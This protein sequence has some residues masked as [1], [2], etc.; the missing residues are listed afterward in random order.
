MCS[1][2]FVKKFRVFTVFF[3][4]IVFM[5]PGWQAV[6]AEDEEEAALDELHRDL[7][8][9]ESELSAEKASPAAEPEEEN[10]AKEVQEP[11]AESEKA[12][13]VAEKSE[14][15]KE[16]AEEWYD[17]EKPTGDACL[18]RCNRACTCRWEL[19]GGGPVIMALHHF[20]Y[21]SGYGNLD[22]FGV[23]AG[24]RGYGY[25]LDD[26]LR[27]GGMG[28]G[29]GLGSNVSQT[30]VAGKNIL[31]D[32]EYRTSSERSI[33]GGY[34]GMTLEYVFRMMDGAF[35]IPL[36]ALVGFG[37]AG[38]TSRVGKVESIGGEVVVREDGM[39]FALQPMA[40]V[41]I[42]AARWLRIGVAATALY[43]PVVQGDL[44]DLS[45]AGVMVNVMFG[46]FTHEALLWE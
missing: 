24:G 38:Y 44:D 15:T 7:L 31:L 11:P 23:W 8:A 18:D 37:G 19:G 2:Q 34:G 5:T 12:P 10:I 27:I 16:S 1:S 46:N 43:T 29:G 30:T 17:Y 36:G 41:D 14:E 22:G 26:Q 6:A 4:M 20:G 13:E 3:F 39:F 25:V 40:G 33:G 42:N 21:D 28:F 35:E 9:A 32:S 45:G